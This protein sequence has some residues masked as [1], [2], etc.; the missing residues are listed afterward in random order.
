MPHHYAT[1]DLDVS[2]VATLLGCKPASGLTNR[3]NELAKSGAIEAG[4]TFGWIVKQVL[5]AELARLGDV[6]RKPEPVNPTNE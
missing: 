1:D 6:A 5:E 4:D 2:V 3:M